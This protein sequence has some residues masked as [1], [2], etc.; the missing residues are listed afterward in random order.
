MKKVFLF[1][2]LCVFLGGNHFLYAQEITRGSGLYQE[3]S[4]E[5]LHPYFEA[6]KNGNVELLKGVLAGKIYGKYK[7]LIEKNNDY[8]EF[9]RNHFQDAEFSV[10]K[11]ESNGNAVSVDIIIQFPGSQPLESKFLLRREVDFS[12][13]GEKGPRWKMVEKINQ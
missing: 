2:C 9:L 7:A 10:G 8:P 1:I 5:A 12:S 3:I 4:V 6:L 11:I 13:S